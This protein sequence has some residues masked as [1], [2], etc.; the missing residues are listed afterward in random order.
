MEMNEFIN[1]KNIFILNFMFFEYNKYLY[2]ITKYLEYYQLD[3]E[4]DETVKRIYKDK[5]ILASTIEF[6]DLLE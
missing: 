1:N 6:N 4:D 5:F 3:E 2:P